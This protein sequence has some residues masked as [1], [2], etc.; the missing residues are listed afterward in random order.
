MKRV[1]NSLFMGALLSMF[2]AWGA[3]N[4]QSEQH[5]LVDR[6]EPVIEE[7]NVQFN[8]LV[9][10]VPPEGKTEKVENPGNFERTHFYEDP[11]IPD[12]VEEAAVLFGLEYNICPEFLEA[13][14]YQESR[15]IPTVYAG[16]CVGLMQV[17]LA[18]PDKQERMEKFGYND[19]DMYEIM[20]NMRVAADYI[21]ELFDLYEDPAEVL[22]R[23]NGDK[24]GLKKYWNGGEVSNYATEI[25]ERSEGLEIKHGKKTEKKEHARGGASML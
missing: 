14:A 11:D 7:V 19:S 22:M 13:I 5:F 2:P 10:T 3:I 24:T 21:A 6:P 23:Y 8:D 16:S 17:N 9:G 25:L 12:D 20:P 1:I 18:C 4:S 15:Y